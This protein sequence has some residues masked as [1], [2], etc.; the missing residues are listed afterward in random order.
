MS[1][2]LLR[3][4]SVQHVTSYI[5]I[6]LESD[7]VL[8]SLVV[9]GEVSETFT[10]RAGHVYFTLSDG[11]ANLKCV[12]FKGVAA[13]QRIP[14]RPGAHVAAAG[15]I[16][17][18][19]RDASYQLYVESLF[20]AGIGAQAML[21]E[22][23]RQALEADGLFDSSRKRPLPELP[24][25][26]GVVTSQQGAVWHDIQTVVKRRYPLAELRLAPAQVQ[27]AH[28]PA[29]LIRGLQRL[30][31]D[32][33]ADIII[34]ARGGG[35]ADDL[36]AFNDEALVRAVFGSPI[37]VISAVGHETD[38]CI[39]DEVADVRAP[40]PTAA[41]ELATPDIVEL[42]AEVERQIGVMHSVMTASV[43]DG[44][45][46]CDDLHR[47]LDRH[48][49]AER[50]ANE[51][52]GIATAVA[53][54]GKSLSLVIDQSRWSQRERVLRLSMSAKTSAAARTADIA[55]PASRLRDLVSGR[56]AVQRDGCGVTSERLR[57]AG[58]HG[59][60][61]HAA[62]L[63]VAESSL[64][65]LDPG[66]VLGRGYALVLDNRGEPLTS[67]SQAPAGSQVS[68]TVHDG[69]LTARVELVEGRAG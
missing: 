38:W 6:L 42:T 43:R 58:A 40:T 14:L 33:E 5:R 27:G 57:L 59:I 69:R 25:V 50:M 41:A 7:D 67:V 39:L 19:D 47:M 15:R 4:L 46:I 26:I 44:Y 65:Q 52:R 62:L 8:R 30:I 13:R 48:S 1:S 2:A 9:E 3:I 31:D 36:S 54:A 35:S 66:A 16:S 34:I 18:Y 24:R 63:E 22:R 10:S 60:Q 56:L 23:L 37:P 32:G 53:Q 61:R 12:M 51:S 68:A 17:V 20:Q 21:L 29:S 64:K 45:R 11:S 55:V 28:A 49:P